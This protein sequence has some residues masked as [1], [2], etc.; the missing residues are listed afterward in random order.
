MSCTNCDIF[1]QREVTL[2]GSRASARLVSCFVCGKAWFRPRADS[3]Q[4]REV[5]DD[6]ERQALE[7][8]YGIEN[9]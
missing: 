6:A 3:F 8:E 4:W 7:A 5:T 9:I 2:P 1:G